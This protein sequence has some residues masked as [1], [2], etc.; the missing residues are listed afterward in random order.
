MES[1][2][3]RPS[4]VSR[5][6]RRTVSN[7]FSRG[8]GGET[9]MGTEQKIGC[10]GALR[11][12]TDVQKRRLDAAESRLILAARQHSRAQSAGTLAALRRAALTYDRVVAVVFGLG[13]ARSVAAAIG[14]APC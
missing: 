1:K 12:L 11:M 13:V 5:N 7:T 4:N 14:G 8:T 9:L 2:K 3:P 10:S 6:A